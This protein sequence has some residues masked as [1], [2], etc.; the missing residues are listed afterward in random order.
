MRKLSRREF[1]QVSALAA[2]GAAVA[3]CAKTEQPTTVP[4]TKL[5]ETQ[6]TPTVKPSTEAAANQAPVLSEMVKAG[7]LPELSE[8]LP[9]KPF[10]VGPGVLIVEQDLDWE[11]GTYDGG[12]LRTVT[13][14]PTW[15]Y[16]CQHALENIINTPKHH[17]GPMSGNIV[18]S[19][20]VSDDVTR[21][22]FTMRKGM[23]WSDGQPLTTDD[24]RFA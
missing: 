10:V 21:Y 5:S 9:I 7:K 19:F 24:V 22:T 18:E 16:P 20:T 13:T 14:N 23:K 17:T 1:I 2:A 6:P 3:A 12:V 4:P 15:S 11:V 8:R